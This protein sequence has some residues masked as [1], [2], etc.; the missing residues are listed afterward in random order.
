MHER[1]IFATEI[2]RA[3]ARESLSS[4]FPLGKLWYVPDD[5]DFIMEAEFPCSLQTFFRYAIVAPGP[6]HLLIYSC[7]H[8]SMM[9][10]EPPLWMIGELQKANHRLPANT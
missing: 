6:A 1:F 8:L 4:N 9:M 2:E 7:F 5:T 10:F 3:A